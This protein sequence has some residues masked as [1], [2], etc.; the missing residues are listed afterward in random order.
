MSP[1]VVCLPTVARDL[2][3]TPYRQATSRRLVLPQYKPNFAAALSG[4]EFGSSV[5]PSAARCTMK[6]AALS[7][8][9]DPDAMQ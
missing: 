2:A 1:R 4:E 9:F 5:P 8:T 6:A 7:S 3:P